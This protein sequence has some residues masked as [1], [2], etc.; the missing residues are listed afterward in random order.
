MNSTKKKLSGHAYRRKALEK[1]HKEEKLVK[2][3]HR[4]DSFFKKNTDEAEASS[5]TRFNDNDSEAMTEV[6]SEVGKLIC[7]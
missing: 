5:S 7:F 3:T 4:I 1:K 2:Q 6:G